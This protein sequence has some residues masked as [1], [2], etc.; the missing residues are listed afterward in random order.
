MY[1]AEG[2]P[3]NRVFRL[4]AM[5]SKSP[6]VM[7]IEKADFKN[8]F[9]HLLTKHPGL[10]FLQATPEFQERYQDTVIMRVFY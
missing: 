6:E 7:I 8:L 5:E 3:Q 2:T 1:F 10:E 4:L 9:K